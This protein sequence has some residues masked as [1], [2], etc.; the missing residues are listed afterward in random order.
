MNKKFALDPDREYEEKE[1]NPDRRSLNELLSIYPFLGESY[2]HFSFVLPTCLYLDGSVDFCINLDG[3]EYPI[4]LTVTQVVSNYDT[5]FGFSSNV[6]VVSDTSAGFRYSK[7]NVRL[8]DENKNIPEENLIKVYEDKV[9]K[10]TN[11]FIDAFRFLSKRPAIQNIDKISNM[12]DF[13]VKRVQKDSGTKAM[14][15][16]SFGRGGAMTIFKPLNSV[17]FHIRL[18]EFI[19]KPESFDLERILIMDAHRQ[20]HFGDDVYALI[21]AITALELFVGKKKEYSLFNKVINRL[22]PY[23]SLERKSKNLYH[24]LKIEDPNLLSLIIGAIRDRHK[25]VHSGKR[26]IKDVGKYISAIE[27]F[28]NKQT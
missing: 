28:I 9:L 23:R 19:A 3:E 10:T 17:D 14:L 26:A 16:I 22:F 27:T 12:K 4:V 7:I 2:I 21:S 1:V 11:H 15:S 13:E 18:Q 8:K 20:K 5:R 6:E 25:V 24:E